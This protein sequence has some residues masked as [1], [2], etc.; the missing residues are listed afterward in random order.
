MFLLTQ[1]LEST[2]YIDQVRILQSKVKQINLSLIHK[3]NFHHITS[4]LIFES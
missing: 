3:K 1:L 2:L 4:A